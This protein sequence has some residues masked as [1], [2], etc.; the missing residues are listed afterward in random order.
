MNILN[1]SP[2]AVIARPYPPFA[3]VPCA[4]MVSSAVVSS[5]TP[6]WRAQ[7]ANAAAAHADAHFAA[8]DAKQVRG[9]KGTKAQG[10]PPPRGTPR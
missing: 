6:S 1:P 5:M 9:G 7:V 3:V 8:R 4:L 10:G 2:A